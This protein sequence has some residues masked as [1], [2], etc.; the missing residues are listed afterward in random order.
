MCETFGVFSSM[1]SGCHSRHT[2]LLCVG[3]SG[4]CKRLAMS[5]FLLVRKKYASFPVGLFKQWVGPCENS[6][7]KVRV[8]MHNTVMSAK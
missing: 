3:A 5:S 1:I 6:C 4:S 2:K 8:T 7:L